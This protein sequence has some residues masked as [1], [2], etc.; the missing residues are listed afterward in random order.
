MGQQTYGY[1]R[2]GAAQL[3]DLAHGESLPRGWADS[4][5]RYGF[6]VF[7][8]VNG[9]WTNSDGAASKPDE[10]SPSQTDVPDADPVT[11]QEPP[12]DAEDPR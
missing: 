10:V 5:T 7:D 11:P 6:D 2:K 12:A 9:R 4:P 8:D 1:N 3:F